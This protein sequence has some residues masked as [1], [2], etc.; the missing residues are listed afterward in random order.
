MQKATLIACAQI[1]H[2]MLRREKIADLHGGSN[3]GP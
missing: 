1:E 3:R 2:H